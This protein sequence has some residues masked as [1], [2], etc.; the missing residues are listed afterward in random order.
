MKRSERGEGTGW[1]RAG[2][3]EKDR[4]MTISG[5]A[6]RDCVDALVR[7]TYCLGEAYRF[8]ERYVLTDVLDEQRHRHETG[9]K[10][11]TSAEG[12]DDRLAC[13]SRFKG[14]AETRTDARRLE[15]ELGAICVSPQGVSAIARPTSEPVAFCASAEPPCC[16]FRLRSVRCLIGYDAG[17]A[18]T[19]PVPV[20]NCLF[21]SVQQPRQERP[22]FT[23]GQSLRPGLCYLRHK[24]RQLVLADVTCDRLFVSI[25]ATLV[26][27]GP[28]CCFQYRDLYVVVHLLCDQFVLCLHC[29]TRFAAPDTL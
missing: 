15:P 25:L 23:E 27:R 4:Q 21:W 24:L 6:K 28:S 18:D 1:Y 8:L 5:S 22:M 3:E 2:E 20:A 7:G 29:N 10:L 26:S 14:A 13:S 11:R 12:Y 17:P 19:I 9:D 16:F